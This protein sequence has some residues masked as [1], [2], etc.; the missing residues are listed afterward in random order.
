MYGLLA[1]ATV[2]IH[3]AYVSFVVFGQ[4]I[5]FVGVSLRWQWIRNAWFRVAH[6]AA[7]GIVA[8]EAI[9]NIPCP[10]TVWEQ[11]L[12]RLSGQPISGESFMGRLLHY[13]IFYDWPS[14]AF[15]TLYIAFA[16]L[17]LGTFFLAP[18]RF[19]CQRPARA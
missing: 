6:L 16:S 2:A 19:A 1:D 3:V 7:I 12:R 11:E 14:W 9:L 15:T 5:I 18:P 10:L 13:L 8:I 4:L 17:V